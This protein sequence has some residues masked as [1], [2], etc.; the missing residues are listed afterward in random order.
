MKVISLGCDWPVRR[1]IAHLEADLLALHRILTLDQGSLLPCS[2]CRGRKLDLIR[3]PH[4]SKQAPN[5]ASKAPETE[6]SDISDYPQAFHGVRT[7][8]QVEGVE[9]ETRLAS[10]SDGE[11]N[12]INTNAQKTTKEECPRS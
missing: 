11:L 5:E 3:L 1:D 12:S 4:P 6:I 10:H 7:P 2:L 8:S 9:F